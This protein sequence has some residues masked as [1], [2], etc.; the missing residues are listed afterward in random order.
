VNSEW[1]MVKSHGEAK[2]VQRSAFSNHRSLRAKRGNPVAR[3]RECF[4]ILDATRWYNVL[5]A[6][7][8]RSDGAPFFEVTSP[9]GKRI[10]TTQ[11]YFRKI[12]GTK[13]PGMRSKEQD[14]KQA[15]EKPDEIRRS[16]T[17]PEVYLYYRKSDTLYTCAVVKHFN[18]EGFLITTYVTDVVKIGEVIWT[19]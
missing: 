9:L 16:K 1:L 14:V 6:T 3:S 5:R 4:T 17:D 18:D 10:R 8:D 19:R 11:E 13:H 12:V 2:S 15:I 7:S